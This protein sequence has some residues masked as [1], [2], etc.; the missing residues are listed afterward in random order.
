MHVRERIASTTVQHRLLHSL[1]V[2]AST[3]FPPKIQQIGDGLLRALA[4]QR[5]LAVPGAHGQI[6]DCSMAPTGGRN[7]R[8]RHQRVLS[9]PK[10]TSTGSEVN[11]S[12]DIL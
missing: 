10:Q 2:E 1:K 12:A 7:R 8:A 3:L 11:G 4:G 9:M 6:L 5:I